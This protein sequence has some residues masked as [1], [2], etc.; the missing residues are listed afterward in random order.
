[1]L[2]MFVVTI[3]I[4][5]FVPISMIWDFPEYANDSLFPLVIISV[6]AMMSLF[7]IMVI[8]D[9]ILSYYRMKQRKD[10]NHKS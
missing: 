7:G 1:M 8:D 6:I 2:G 3:I 4:I 5:P 9:G 10:Y